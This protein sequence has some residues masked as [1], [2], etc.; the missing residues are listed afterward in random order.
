MGHAAEAASRGYTTPADA[1]S[2]CTYIVYPGKLASVPTERRI[3]Q[4]KH[5]DTHAGAPDAAGARHAAAH[6]GQQAV[7]H[8][9]IYT[10]ASTERANVP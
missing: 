4:P 2:A 7:E 10:L 9:W 3:Q 5:Q 8:H 6:L 1:A